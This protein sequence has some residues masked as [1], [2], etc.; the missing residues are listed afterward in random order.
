M[1]DN[2]ASLTNFAT[3]LFMLLTNNHN[4]MIKK[5]EGKKAKKKET[6]NNH[7]ISSIKRQKELNMVVPNFTLKNIIYFM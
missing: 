1:M 5:F 7:Y 3:C 4:I 2:K 6:I